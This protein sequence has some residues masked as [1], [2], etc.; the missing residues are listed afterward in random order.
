MIKNL[1]P[2]FKCICICDQTQSEQHVHHKTYNDN[3]NESKI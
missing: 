1:S 3:T 2:L